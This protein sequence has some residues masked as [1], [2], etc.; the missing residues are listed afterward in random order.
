MAGYQQKD[1]DI[2]V[3]FEREPK[4]EKSPQWKGRALINGVEME[5]AFWQKSDTML[6]GSI[7]PARA[8][9]EGFQRREEP[10]GDGRTTF[11]DVPFDDPIPW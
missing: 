2:A 4:T 5:V 3:F 9:G 6:A 11:D 7:K 8:K 1:G 10:K